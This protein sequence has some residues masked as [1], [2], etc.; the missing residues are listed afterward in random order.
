V[1]ISALTLDS[2]SSLQGSAELE[3]YNLQ[4]QTAT[5]LPSVLSAYTCHQVCISCFGPS[6]NACEEFFPLVNLQTTLDIPSGQ[7]QIFTKT[8][9]TFRGRTY[10]SLSEYALTGWLQIVSSN[11]GIAWCEVLR[12]TSYE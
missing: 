12:F 2:T 11:P 7:S 3:L 1:Q 5:D 6:F 8:D 9:R 4:L 10:D